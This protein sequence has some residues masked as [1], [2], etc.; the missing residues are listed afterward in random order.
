MFITFEGPEGS[1]KSTQARLLADRL[2]AAGH[3]VLLTREPGGT[4]LGDQIRTLLLDHVHGEMHAVTEALLF[5]AD[6]AQ[7]V[8]ER[9][10]PHLEQ[11]GV[12]LCDRFADSTFAYQGYGLGQDLHMLRA[13][14]TIATGGLHPDLT[15]L[16]DLS[17]DV[18]LQRKRQAQHAEEWNR[19]DA[20]ELAFHRRVRHGYDALVAAEPQ[21]WRVFDAQQP[22]NTLGEQIWLQVARRLSTHGKDT[23]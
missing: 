12:V 7:H 11:G 18:G 10:R 14:T 21:R 15:L 22:V 4:A 16:L 3:D 9:M 8:H 13:L 19:L 1:G 23:P 5:A 2:R 20:R 6:R 17:V